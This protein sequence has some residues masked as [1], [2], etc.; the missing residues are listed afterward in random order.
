MIFRG[1]DSH[2]HGRPFTATRLLHARERPGEDAPLRADGRTGAV[3]S[4]SQHPGRHPAPRAPAGSAP[5]HR[6]SD[7]RS[8]STANALPRAAPC[9]LDDLPCDIC[10]A[11]ADSDSNPMLLCDNCDSGFHLRCVELAAVPPGDWYCDGCSTVIES[12]R[13][14]RKKGLLHSSNWISVDALDFGAGDFV[15][16]VYPKLGASKVQLYLAQVIRI[17]SNLQLGSDPSEQVVELEHW[18]DR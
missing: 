12:Q 9:T 15:I 7:R 17:G 8:R 16:V 6:S 2:A 3:L 1:H 18:P 10:G 14:L 13:W 11:V 5:S 4:R